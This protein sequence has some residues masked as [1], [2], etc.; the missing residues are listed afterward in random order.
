[1]GRIICEGLETTGRISIGEEWVE[2]GSQV[3]PT[4]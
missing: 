4:A 1:M 3:E 2:L